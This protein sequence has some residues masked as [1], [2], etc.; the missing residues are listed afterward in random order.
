MY[1]ELKESEKNSNKESLSERR[2]ERRS[3]RKS[4]RKS[5]SKSDRRSERKS[6]RES[7]E[8]E[9]ESEKDAE[10]E[11]K[12]NSRI[13]HR[14]MKKIEYKERQ[15]EK[16]DKASE[17]LE[18][19]ERNVPEGKSMLGINLDKITEIMSKAASED[20]DD[21]YR[22]EEEAES[23]DDKSDIVSSDYEGDGKGNEEESSDTYKEHE[24]SSDRDPCPLIRKKGKPC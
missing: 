23:V 3:E 9:K 1:K 5:E 6:E 2:H 18:L 8:S 17:I 13:P 22:F 7:E 16:R 10:N 24:D 19:I 12:S 14:E 4:E 21:D 11:L 20:I 15:N